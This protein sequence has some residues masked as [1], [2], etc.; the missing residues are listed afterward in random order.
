LALGRKRAPIREVEVELV[1]PAE[2]ADY[3]VADPVVEPHGMPAAPPFV[4]PLPEPV[5][6]A[7]TAPVDDERF[8]EEAAEDIPEPDERPSP[9]AFAERF[10]PAAEP[11]VSAVPEP[12]DDERPEEEPG[13]AERD[14]PTPTPSS[15]SPPPAVSLDQWTCEI[16]LWSEHA[17]AVF[18]AR[19]FRDGEEITIAESTLFPLG[20]DGTVE[21][22][23][24]ALEAHESLCEEL[25]HA[26]WQRVGR[27][28]E[29][30][31]D[32]FRRDFSVGALNA[33]LTTRIAFAR[34]P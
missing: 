17:K 29:W 21:P 10:A 28:V 26:G 34:R 32:R 22:T 5:V 24:T 25:A 16:A 7:V 23:D 19:S 15:T 6:S 2:L 31:G 3:G 14:D 18:Y 1:T 8:D 20:A 4:S 11:A 9:P 12:L 27:G 33:S 30:Y 13:E